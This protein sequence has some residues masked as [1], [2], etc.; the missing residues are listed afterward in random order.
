MLNVVGSK[1]KAG[2]CPTKLCSSVSI[3]LFIVYNVLLFPLL[4]INNYLPIVNKSG[5]VVFY[6]CSDPQC[7]DTKKKWRDFIKRNELKS[8]VV[9]SP[10]YNMQLNTTK[11]NFIGKERLY[12]AL[13]AECL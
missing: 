4:I 1:N 2:K 9:Y 10:T 7:V 5:V 3:V 6:S 13:K 11:C 12:T 8:T